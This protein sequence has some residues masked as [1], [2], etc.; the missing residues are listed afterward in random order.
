M[1][2]NNKVEKSI[3]TFFASK[4]MLIY[5]GS[6]LISISIFLWMTQEA[7]ILS[8]MLAHTNT[9]T[10]FYSSETRNG[11]NRINGVIN[12]LAER[13]ASFYA[14][15]PLRWEE[16]AEFYIDSF[17]GIKNIA[18]V[19]QLF[20]IQR[21]SPSQEKLNYL[22]KLVDQVDRDPLDVNLWIPSYN[23][24]KFN[25]F[26]LA[27]ISITEILSPVLAEIQNDYMLKVSRE[28]ND[29]FSSE[30]WNN[31]PAEISANE[32]INFPGTAVFTLFL[33]PTQKY[34]NAQLRQSYQTLIYSL[35]FSC[36]VLVSIYFTQKYNWAAKSIDLRYKQTLENMVEGYQIIGRDW[37]YLFVNDVAAG[38]IQRTKEEMIGSLLMEVQ[39]GIEKT[40][41]FP[42]LQLCM[43]FRHPQEMVDKS[44]FSDGSP[45]W[46]QYSIQPAPD[47]I[48][49]LSNDVTERVKATE[50]I[51]KLNAGLEQRVAE[52][53]FQLEIANRELE[54]FSYS[55]SHDLRAPLRA[56]SGFS[57]ILLEEHPGELSQESLR[58]LNLIRNNSNKMGVLIDELLKFSRI[59]N[60]DLNI[61]KIDTSKLI[62]QVLADLD[63]EG[64]GL[65]PKVIVGKMYACQADL[66][67]LTQVFVNLLS[68]AFKFTRGIAN[69][70]VEIGSKV[71][72]GET[73]Y[74][75]KDNGVGFDMR[76]ADKL[77]GVFQR[78]HTEVEFE[79]TGVGLA[80][81][82]RIIQR[83]GGR[84][85]AES[86]LSQG[87][88]FYFTLGEKNE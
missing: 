79:G 33:A 15:N 37:R 61:Q 10:Q 64:G 7:R 31:P 12:V 6:V 8:E 84:V 24:V 50:E 42:L 38:Q 4:I 13:E 76:Y 1:R 73:I 78:L 21:F 17:E 20:K 44:T 86:E 16:D 18:W 67:L 9:K 3:R 49:I 32:T 51:K 19:D 60:N 65:K 48:L 46:Y 59:G 25:G 22:N 11:Y 62:Q 40:D 71:E 36:M 27:T 35:L 54:A 29:F 28:G 82:Q 56:I 52:R 77:F 5:L 63:S 83:H 55:V 75:V 70:R 66:G 2:I 74:F 69:G 88:T 87:S 39:P 85:W 68:N 34:I 41:L 72:K 23:G 81:V 43:E 30:N 14:D 26:V 58:Y 45:V 53:T 47:G 80:I 57:N